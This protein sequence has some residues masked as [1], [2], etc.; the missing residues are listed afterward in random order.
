MAE[1]DFVALK[2]KLL[3]FMDEHIYPNEQLFHKQ[4]VEIG[5]RLVKSAFQC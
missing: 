5:V 3:R 4:N 1:P 2:T